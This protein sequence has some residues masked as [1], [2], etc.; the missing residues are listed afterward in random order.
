MSALCTSRRELSN[1]YLLP[2][3]G[4]DTA[5]NEPSKVCPPKGHQYRSAS[6]ARDN[7][8]AAGRCAFA[9]ME[10]NEAKVFIGGLSPETT[11]DKLKA[12][13]EQFGPFACFERDG[14]RNF[15]FIHFS[16]DMFW[17]VSWKSDPNI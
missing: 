11:E 12:H 5:E 10:K 1:A 4:L 14:R 2:K 9:M 16:S 7:S 15:L 8:R 13:F 17:N 6:A 3:F